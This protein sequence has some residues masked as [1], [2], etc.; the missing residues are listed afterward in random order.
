M[1]KGLKEKERNDFQKHHTLKHLLGI[2]L[3][4]FGVLLAYSNSLNGIWAFDDVLINQPL[5]TEGLIEKIGARKIAYLTFLINQKINPVDPFNFRLFNIFIH[6]LNALLVYIIALLTLSYNCS[7]RPDKSV[8]ARHEVPKQS[9]DFFPIALFSAALFALHPLN[10]NAVAYIIQRMASLATFFVLLS[11]VSYIFANMAKNIFNKVILYLVTIVFIVLGV[12]SKENA[13]MAVPLILLYDYIFLSRYDKKTFLKKALV[14]LSIGFCT[15]L[16]FTFYLPIHKTALDVVKAFTDIN[17]PLIYKSWMAT[18]VYWSPIEHILTGFRVISR[19]LFL[20]L[21]PLPNFLVFDWWGYPLS[22]GIFEPITTIFSI[23]LIFALIVFSV[24]KLKKYPFLSF[25]ILWYFIAISLES[26]IAVGSDL[27]FEHRNYLP[28]TGL[29]FGLVAQV[30]NFL[31]EK[32]SAKYAPWVVFFVLSTF[33]GFM[34][35]Q[36]NFIWKDPVTFWGDTVKKAPYNIRANLA[37]AHSYRAASDFQ[38]AQNYYLTSVRIAVEEK[39]PF[40]TVESLYHLGFMH[41]LLEQRT[42]AGK[43][44]DMLEKATPDSYKLRILM[45]YYSYLNKDFNAAV[46]TYLDVLKDTRGTPRW[47]KVTVYTLL[48][49]AY[50][51]MGLADKAMGSYEKALNL[52]H[53]FPAAYHGMAKVHLMKGDLK[54]ASEYLRKVLLVDPYNIVALSDM[55]HLVLL[56]G[57]GVD[58]ALPFAKKAVSFNP[59]VY[60]PY[61]IMG[62]I[63]T[64]QGED[65]DAEEFYTTA[66]DFHAPEY[67]VLFNRAWAYS[68]KGERE[69]QKYYLSK[70]LNMKRVPNNIRNT[71]KKILS[72]L[73]D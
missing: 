69:K 60:K 33:L 8:I 16:A 25:G 67:L 32:V 34:T 11:L 43:V 49:D 28:L 53:S 26:L 56:G 51:D 54:T 37:L 57:G 35:F 70:L 61:L 30:A 71:A 63:L 62:T 38:N 22:K 5:G 31:K 7:E 10:I 59:P 47:D 1:R 2:A 15:L 20:F 58:K 73:T 52:N 14:I 72:K 9:Q 42:E 44:I 29:S 27:Y 64:I 21:L 24:L 45:G 41:L 17:K 36:R 68:L 3:L 40:F 12:L 4:I 23:A 6:I 55:A 19:Y 46:E 13:I 50:R 65:A 48:G 18:D 66:K 39:R